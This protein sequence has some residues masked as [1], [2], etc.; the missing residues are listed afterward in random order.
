MY[1]IKKTLIDGSLGYYTFEGWQ[2]FPIGTPLDLV[3]AVRF[4]KGEADNIK[5]SHGYE[6]QEFG[7]YKELK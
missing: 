7:C 5:L 1:I 4:T 6:F 2:V 3:N